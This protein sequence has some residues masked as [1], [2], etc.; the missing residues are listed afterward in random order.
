M[1][2]GVKHKDLE[3]ETTKKYHLLELENRNL[4][5]IILTNNR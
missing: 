2:K 1:R 3:L 5:I 4:K